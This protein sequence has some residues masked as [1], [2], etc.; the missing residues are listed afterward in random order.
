[1]AKQVTVTRDVGVNEP[2]NFLH[3]PVA[4]GEVF[5]KCDLPTYGCINYDGGIALT[6]QPGEYPFFEF[7][8]DAIE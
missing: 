1:M 7:P 3:R 5:Y 2:H 4:E 6:E 8:R